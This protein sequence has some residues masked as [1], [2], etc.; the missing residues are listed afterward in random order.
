[1]SPSE[2]TPLLASEL[3]PAR[4][5]SPS[6]SDQDTVQIEVEHPSVVSLRT[7]ALHAYINWSPHKKGLPS[8]LQY[9]QVFS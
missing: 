3:S 5:T 1:M 4:P 7:S 8:W 6:R 2:T 9:G